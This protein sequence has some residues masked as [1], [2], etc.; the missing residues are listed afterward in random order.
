MELAALIQLL[1][2]EIEKLS[3]SW[4]DETGK[5]IRESM[6]VQLDNIKKIDNLS[7][8]FFEKINECFSLYPS[9]EIESYYRSMLLFINEE[10]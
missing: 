5:K 4:N 2:D 3:F 10:D 8:E 9:E 7:R 1:E 6:I